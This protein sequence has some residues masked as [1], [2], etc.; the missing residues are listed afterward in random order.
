[1]KERTERQIAGD[2]RR[3]LNGACRM[4]PEEREAR[5]RKYRDEVLADP[6]RRR[7][8]ADY[9][10]KR[11]ARPGMRERENA[12]ARARYN[13]DVEKSREKCREKYRR[14]MADP[15]RHAALLERRKKRRHGPDGKQT[16][17]ARRAQI[18]EK[19]IPLWERVI[20]EGREDAYRRRTTHNNAL[21]FHM[22]VH[23]R[24]LFNEMLSRAVAKKRN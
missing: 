12:Q 17:A 15:E 13:A 16:A 10:R 1:M 9:F 4:T 5:R 20:A 24:P 22:Y 19:L 11:R 6:F 2:R 21:L 23:N 7:Q 8:Y 18:R 3:C 14:M